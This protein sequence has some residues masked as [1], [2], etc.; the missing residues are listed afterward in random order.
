MK[1]LIAFCSL[2]LLMASCALEPKKINYGEDG[3]YYCSMT[4]VDRQHAAQLI[5]KKGKVYNFDAAECMIHSL[6]DFEEDKIG[7]YLVTD[8][9]TPE[10]LIDAKSATYIVSPEI[11]SPMRANLA[12]LASKSN[13][14]E[15][16]QAK[17]GKLY[18]WEEIKMLLKQ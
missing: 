10:K 17:G 3:C 15:L 5:T 8:Y 1:I 6:P 13:A 9:E 16:Q 2:L 7:R 4:I 11:P 12:A 18:T 14:V